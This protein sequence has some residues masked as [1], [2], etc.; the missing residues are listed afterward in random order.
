[1]TSCD[2]NV[3]TFEPLKS[4][5]EWILTLK[6]A[7]LLALTSLKQIGNL[8]ALSITESCLDF[9]PG[10]VKITLRPRPGYVPKVLSTTF[11]FPS[12]LLHWKHQDSTYSICSAELS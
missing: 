3:L 1:M 12:C 6:V 11:R 2:E 5:P 9:A 4:A 7:L 10:L 8:Q